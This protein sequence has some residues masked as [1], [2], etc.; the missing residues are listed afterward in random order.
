MEAR[1][2][3]ICDMMEWIRVK[4]LVSMQTRRLKGFRWDG[5]VWP[6]IKKM[7]ADR[8]NKSRCYDLV[9]AD[10]DEHEI[11]EWSVMENDIRCIVNM[12]NRSC[13]C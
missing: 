10:N 9:F 2:K 4:L 12:R 11:L 13:T 6:A 8:R 1:S 3:L 5:K 7:L